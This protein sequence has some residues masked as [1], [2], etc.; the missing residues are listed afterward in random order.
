MKRSRAIS[1]VVLGTATLITG[2]QRIEKETQ[3]LTQHQYAS[4]ADCERDWKDANACQRSSSSGGGYVGPRYYWHRSS[5]TPVAV[6]PDGSEKAMPHSALA[7]GRPS[8][9]KGTVTSSRA[10][11][12]S[13][14]GF[15]GFGSTAHASS[16]GG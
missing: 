10:V 12:V 16:A 14:G 9:S 4:Q 8:A 3:V 13:R 1:L 6:M 11:W 15:G 2:C 7:E 5:G